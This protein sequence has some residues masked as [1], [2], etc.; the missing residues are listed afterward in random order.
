MFFNDV[1]LAGQSRAD[2][3]QASRVPQNFGVYWANLPDLFAGCF[4]LMFQRRWESPC[5]AAVTACSLCILTI[6]PK[7]PVG[8]MHALPESTEAYPGISWQRQSSELEV[9]A[10]LVPRCLIAA[11]VEQ[12]LQISVY[13]PKYICY[14]LEN[15]VLVVLS[16]TSSKSF[17]FPVIAVHGTTFCVN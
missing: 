14:L 10:M 15:Y 3:R 4:P 5:A 6:L 7:V 2:A 1:R 11:A 13:F 9:P 16:Q 8:H 12:N 17:H